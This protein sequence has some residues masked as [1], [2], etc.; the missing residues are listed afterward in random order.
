MVD[1]LQTSE[2]VVANKRLHREI[3]TRQDLRSR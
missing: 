2:I 3:L 1:F